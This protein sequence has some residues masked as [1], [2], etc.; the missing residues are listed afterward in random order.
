M[1]L[2]TIW[3]SLSTQADL[4]AIGF[5][6]ALLVL[7]L[8]FCIGHLVAWTYMITHSGLSYSQMFTSSLVVLPVLVSATM[9]LMFAN[10][11]VAIGLFAVISVVRFRN[12]LKDTRDTTFVLW[13]I[14]QGMACGT[15]KFGISVTAALAIS[16]IFLYMKFTSF[17]GRHRYDVVLSLQYSGGP[18]NIEGLKSLLRR[19]AVR[20]NLAS[21]RDLD[22]NN[23]DLSYRLLLRDPSRSRELIKELEWTPGIGRVAI[24]HRQ[25]ESE[26]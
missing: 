15:Q 21:Q 2:A 25:D 17:G 4:T 10:V 24:Y 22:G 3:D 1:I 26:I 13:A 16:A 14:M 9:M 6:T 5:E 7:G 18:E 12:V 11:A 8:S 20:A 23:V 19:H